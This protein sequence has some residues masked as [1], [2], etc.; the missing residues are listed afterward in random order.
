MKELIEQFVKDA[1]TTNRDANSLEEF[2][3][4][5][6]AHDEA[7]DKKEATENKVARELGDQTLSSV[8]SGLSGQSFYDE[9]TSSGIYF[10]SDYV[11]IYKT[12]E[13]GQDRVVATLDGSAREEI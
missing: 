11:E 1:S 10:E 7:S 2:K 4:W 6:E 9:T 3:L 13:D 12:G 5:L 8:I